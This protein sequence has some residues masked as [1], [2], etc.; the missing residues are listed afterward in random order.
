MAA[1]GREAIRTPDEDGTMQ[2]AIT[3]ADGTVGKQAVSALE[4]TDC[5]VTPL[6][7][8]KSEELDSE[9]VDVTN[10]E[11]LSKALSG[12][13]TVVHLAANP[14]PEADWE[15]VREVNVEGT[16]NVF[17][18]AIENDIDR[19][20]FSSSNHVAHM[21]NAADPAEPES[22]VETPVVV[23]PDSPPRPDSFYGVSKV[24][25]EALG[26]YYADR[27]GLEVVNLR[28]GWLM[29]SENLEDTQKEGDEHA[30]FARAMWLSPHDCQ[31]AIEAAVSAELPEN[32]ITAN[33]ISANDDRYLSLTQTLQIGYR[34]RDNAT[35][36]LS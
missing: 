6:T 19:V 29:S 1:S 33:V 22:M 2:I 13:D 15:D 10:N 11:D 16:Y 8:S 4:G 14:S 9:I 32:P 20:V 30:R 34:P 7:H 5:S 25:G 27:Y 24:T 3:G 17:Q 35:E 21:K 31:D 18:S 28:I 12:H 36:S 23:G 26:S